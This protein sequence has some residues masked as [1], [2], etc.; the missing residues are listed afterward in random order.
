MAKQNLSYSEIAPY[1]LHQFKNESQ[2][3][4]NVAQMGKLFNHY[5]ENL[6]EY[7]EDKELIAAYCAYYLTTNYPKLFGVLEMVADKI[8]LSDFD[9][10]IDVGTG[11]GTFLLALA[12]LVDEKVKLEGIDVSDMMLDQASSI[13]K[14]LRP[15]KNV[16]LYKGVPK[17]SEGKTLLLFTHS[18][19]EM[20]SEQAVEY[21]KESKPEAIM[22]I[23]PGTKEAFAKCLKL[24]EWV[25]SEGYNVSYPC[26]TNSACPLNLEEDWCHQFIS[27]EHSDD[28]ERMTQKLHRNRRL[29]PLTVQIYSKEAKAKKENARLIRVK[30][31]TKHSVEWELC[32]EDSGNNMV[33]NAEIPKRGMSK[34]ETKEIEAVMSGVEVE[35]EVQKEF[36]EKKRIKLLSCF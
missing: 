30:K 10:V 9:R 31:P 7:R 28:V 24:R 1:L 35:F 3:L 4:K 12:E 22:L 14:G 33:F 16:E 20:T 18:L 32:Q 15:Q 6:N 26:F 11:P 13:L 2:L 36:E 5:R 23:E 17:E 25:I 21:V 27:V 8:E 19:N 29:L 34:K